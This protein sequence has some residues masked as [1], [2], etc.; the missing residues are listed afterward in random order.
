MKKV[1]LSLAIV[2]IGALSA[3]AQSEKAEAKPFT[4]SVGVNAGLPIG[5]FKP[6]YSFVIGGDIQGQYS[7][8]EN[9][10]LTLSAGY[11]NYSGK[12][13]VESSS[14]IPVLAGVKYYFTPGG[15]YGHAQLGVS[16]LSDGGG[17]AFTYAPGIGYNLSPNFD[18]GVKYQAFTKNS[19]TGS[20]IGLRAA[21][22]F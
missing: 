7:V 2:A 22:N 19:V 13:G 20:F 12:D 10:G 21:Y 16:F 1:I 8:A 14:A 17:S 18:L 5:D 15:F 9:L 4:F 3:S 11:L 6:F